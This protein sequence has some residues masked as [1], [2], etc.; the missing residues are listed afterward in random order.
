MKI[1]VRVLVAGNVK[2]P[3]KTVSL[4]VEGYKAIRRAEE[5]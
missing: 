3:K 5:V 2:S 1:Y 4:R